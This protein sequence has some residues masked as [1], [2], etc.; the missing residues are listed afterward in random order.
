MTSSPQSTGTDAAAELAARGRELAQRGQFADALQLL[1]GAPGVDD[2]AEALYV[3][4][5]CCRRLNQRNRALQ[6]LQRV[7]ELAPRYARAYQE[8]GHVHKAAGTA[9]KAI[10]GYEAAVNINPA[11][12]ASWNGLIELYDPQRDADKLAEARHQRDQLASLPMELQEVTSYLHAAISHLALGMAPEVPLVT[13]SVAAV[14]LTKCILD[15]NRWRTWL[16]LG[17]VLGLAGLS[18]YTAITLALSVILALLC[19]HRARLLIQLKSMAAALIAFAVISPVLI[20]NW[21]HDWLSFRYQSAYQLER[22]SDGPAWS[23]QDALRAD[24]GPW[25]DRVRVRAWADELWHDRSSVDDA[26]LTTLLS[27]QAVE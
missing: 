11:L 4:A 25:F 17:M 19:A 15:H 2:S 5:V 16:T 14:W 10:Q 9:S 13:L 1:E 21:Q 7:H 27:C 24:L 23:L 22:N 18:K 20:W 3:C 12:L 8:I 6:Y 26:V